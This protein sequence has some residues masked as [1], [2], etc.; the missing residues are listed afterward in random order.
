VAPNVLKRDFEAKRP[1]EK[2]VADITYIPTEEGW[3]YLA[4]ALDLYS[5]RVVGWA[6]SDRMTN[7]L[8]LSALR[9]A[10]QQRE[11]DPALIHHSDRAPVMAFIFSGGDPLFPAEVGIAQR[12]TQRSK[13]RWR[14]SVTHGAGDDGSIKPTGSPEQ[15]RHGE[16]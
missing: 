3:L 6:M 8:T 4:A 9:M 14:Q 11:V 7:D 10:V 12:L 13:G 16:S 2:W 15:A 1:N 5:R